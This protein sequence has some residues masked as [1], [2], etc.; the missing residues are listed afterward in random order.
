MGK[1][2][3]AALTSGQN[4]LREVLRNRISPL[5]LLG[6]YGFPAAL[7][8]ALTFF[9]STGAVQEDDL[10]WHLRT[11]EWILE[12]RELPA[13]DP[14]SYTT[15]QDS[16]MVTALLR[17][18]WLGQIALYGLWQLGGPAGIVAARAL[19]YA[20]IV[21]V[22]LLWFRR[23]AQ[24][25]V[26][27]LG[28]ALAAA[29]LREF[30][31]ERPQLFS[32]L[33]TP[34]VLAIL[35]TRRGLAALPFIMLFWANLHGG[36]LLGVGVMLIFF[37]C[38]VLG[39][40]DRRFLSY[41]GVSM[42]AAM[43]NPSGWRS[44]AEFLS[45]QTSYRQ[46]LVEHLSPL[47]AAIGMHQWY[48]AYWATLLLLA[49][50]AAIG[51]RQLS[52]APAL[53]ALA[54]AGLSLTS[55]R[56]IAFLPF[57]LPLL[58]F[59]E[60]WRPRKA[61]P[62]LALVAAAALAVPWKECFRFGLSETF[63]VQAVTYM[64]QAGLPRQLFNFYSWGGYLIWRLRGAP[65][66]ID[67]RTLAEQPFVEYERALWSDDSE[68]LLERHGIRTVILPGASLST[69]RTY[70][71]VLRLAQDPRWQ[72]VYADERAVVF[73]RGAAAPALPRRAVY[74]H[75]VGLTG[76]LLAEQPPLP[77]QVL[78]SRGRALFWLGDHAGALAALREAQRLD[79]GNREIGSV[80]RMIAPSGI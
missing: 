2:E 63:P 34:I 53:T 44:L 79:P 73:S 17:R 30:P 19:T 64:E 13:A 41:L 32:F 12:H 26:P 25:L 21:G 47:Q 23:R 15:P 70:P 51:R 50:L 77:A 10:F 56:F 72:P 61:L 38:E 71:L 7:L 11:G 45:T 74:E 49:V 28:C 65:V 20:L 54:L 76:R 24:G 69:G 42:A 60:L 1:T 16:T 8:L 67:G 33:L 43:L 5:A 59:P 58:R 80:L 9:M 18:Y 68:S 66:F 4:R 78:L 55:L 46:A 31:N 35:D 27:L 48:P 57:A 3:G 6:S 40:K 22:L 37:G 29:L 39:K 75:L 14:F 36:Y 52:P 62:A